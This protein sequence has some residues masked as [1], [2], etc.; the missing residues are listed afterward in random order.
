MPDN[1]S[2]DEHPWWQHVPKRRRTVIL[3]GSRWR[4]G[5]E[6][7]GK[8]KNLI[9]TITVCYFI[10]CL[11]PIVF[12]ARILSLL[13]LVPLIFLPALLCL[14]WWLAWNEFHH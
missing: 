9:V 11:V 10:L 8:R 14:I 5:R 13:A 7:L 1:N 4:N 6:L 12:G 3:F 2:L